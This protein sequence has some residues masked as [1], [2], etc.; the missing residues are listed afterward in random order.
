MPKVTIS[1]TIDVPKLDEMSDEVMGQLLFDTIIN[2][3]TVCHLIDAR[4]WCVKAKGDESSTE[5][6]ISEHHGLWGDII[7][8]G[9]WSF[10]R[11]DT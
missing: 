4:K 7:D 10:K 1:L 5:H 9:E 11:L 3:S 6:T 2:Y 8:N